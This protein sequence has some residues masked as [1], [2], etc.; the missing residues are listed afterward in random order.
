[1]KP[2]SFMKAKFRLKITDI[3]KHRKFVIILDTDKTINKTSKASN[4]ESSV[5][6]LFFTF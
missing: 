4:K 6:I 1:M 2:D 3:H 5:L